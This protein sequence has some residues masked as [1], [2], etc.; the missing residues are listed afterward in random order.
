MPIRKAGKL[1]GPVLSAGY[2]KEYGA[3]AM[4]MQRGAL[5]EGQRVV[6]VDDLL[7]T[8]GTMRGAVELCRAAGG[9]VLQCV[10]LIELLDLHGRSA[11][12]V[13]VHSFIQYNGD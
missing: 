6:I 2:E 11:V 9:E 8:G 1:P 7:A 3:D 4:Q 5:R 12:H 13:P 10:V